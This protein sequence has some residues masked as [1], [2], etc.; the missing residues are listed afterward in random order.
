MIPKGS[1]LFHRFYAAYKKSVIA[2]YKRVKIQNK[3]NTCTS[4]YRNT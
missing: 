2:A 1:Y 3:H 4:E